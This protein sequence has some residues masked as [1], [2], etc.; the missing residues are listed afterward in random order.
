MKCPVNIVVLRDVLDKSD[1]V[2][3][4]GF[5]IDENINILM[6]MFMWNI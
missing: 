5:W 3:V 4:G 6:V 1:F 2:V